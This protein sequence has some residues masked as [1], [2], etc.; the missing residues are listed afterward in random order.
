[1]ALS[2]KCY[3]SCSSS[4]GSSCV[5]CRNWMQ[6][7]WLRQ[8]PGITWKS[9]SWNQRM[10]NWITPSTAIRYNR[11]RSLMTCLILS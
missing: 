3:S 11:V 4:I 10:L 5:L 8:A 9:Q 6:R 1:M 7:H 2:R